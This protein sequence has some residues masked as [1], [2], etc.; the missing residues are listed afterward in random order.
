MET[1]ILLSSSLDLITVPILS[2][3]NLLK[4]GGNF[5]YHAV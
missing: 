4:P 1:K 5:T 2:E 3:I